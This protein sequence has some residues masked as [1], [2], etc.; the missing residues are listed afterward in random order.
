LL[1]LASFT[2]A[3]F[4][5]A[6]QQAKHAVSGFS[7]PEDD[8]PFGNIKDLALAS[9]G[10]HGI[11]SVQGLRSKGEMFGVSLKHRKPPTG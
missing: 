4:D 3:Q 2:P 1:H 7:G 10:T 5:A 9:Q 6:F 8:P 11:E